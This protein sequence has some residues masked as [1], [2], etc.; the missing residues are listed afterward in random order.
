M[1]PRNPLSITSSKSSS[2]QNKSKE[3]ILLGIFIPLLV[4]ILIGV[5]AYFCWNRRKQRQQL[6]NVIASKDAKRNNNK[7]EKREEDVWEIQPELLQINFIDKLGS[8]AFGDVFIGKLL[9]PAPI[10]QIYN[11]SPHCQRFHDCD[12]AVKALPAMQVD[13]YARNEFWKEIDFMKNLKFH[14]NLV[15]FLGYVYDP[16][17]P[18]MLLEYCANGDLLKFI[19][20][21]KQKF[22]DSFE[23]SG[24]EDSKTLISFAWQISSGLE[25]LSS[26]DLIHRDIA[27]RNILLDKNNVCKVSDFGKGRKAHNQP[28]LLS[29]GKLQIKWMALESLKENIFSNKT[30]VW[31]YG[32]LLWELYTLGNLPY[33]DVESVLSFLES[34]QRLS[35]PE[36]STDE[37]YEIMIDCWQVDPSDRP[38]FTII[39]QLLTKMIETATL[40]Y[41]YVDTLA[42]IEEAN[43]NVIEETVQIEEIEETNQIVQIEKIEEANQ[44]VQIEEI[45]ETNQIE[46][47][48]SFVE[49]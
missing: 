7:H 6:V 15:C 32:V 20:S 31:S 1:E 43:Q 17:N 40:H 41:N 48:S 4:I 39:C 36:Y 37:I 26:L 2:S 23:N 38:T 12:V 47:N 34:G 21:N 29:G 28:S 19:K 33:S 18:L 30:D 14:Q 25:Y 45:E 3:I 35:K 24:Q 9:G 27:A 22:V 8:G 46:S 16:T 42:L 44:I 13:E 10:T 49:I 5:V 11:D